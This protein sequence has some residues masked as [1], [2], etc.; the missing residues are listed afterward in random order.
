MVVVGTP[1][2]RK[3]CY[4]QC[5]LSHK[6]LLIFLSSVLLYYLLNDDIAE[7]KVV[8]RRHW[9]E[10]ITI[11]SDW[12]RLQ[13][14]G[15][16]TNSKQIQAWR[17][18]LEQQKDVASSPLLLHS[19]MTRTTQKH[20]TV[21]NLRKC[22][23]VMIDLGSN[24]GDA[25]HKFIDSFLPPIGIN[26]KTGEGIHY[27]FNTTTGGIGPENYDDSPFEW[28]LPQYIREKIT[29]YN[30]NN[31]SSIN[32][33]NIHPE[34]Y[35]FYGVEGNPYFTPILRELEINV[36]NMIPR[37]VKH[38]HFLTEHVGTAI[39]GP[40]TL[41]LD[42]VN[43]K[44]NFWGSSIIQSHADVQKSSNSNGQMQTEENNKKEAH[45]IGI[46]LT[47]LLEQT[48]LAGGHVIIKID[49]EGAEYQ[50][51]EEAV[52]SSIFCRLVKGMGVTIDI[53]GEFHGDAT[54]GS[55]EPRKRWEN[56][57]RGEEAIKNC[58]A[59]Y[60]VVNSLIPIW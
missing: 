13:D 14:D 25:L 59:S 39:D 29:L 20:L 57:I 58:G 44:R 23:Y 4:P 21:S 28:L 24:I 15:S 3:T 49:I 12:E 46:T 50:L 41:F 6:V 32:N 48:V 45:V 56:I 8:F 40:T 60:R 53:L 42:T 19:T 38:L 10:T 36:L 33:N 52:R 5:S 27:F 54:L 37:P 9:D 16:S 35:C 34:D 31:Y 55:E 2:R 51:L 18:D 22:Q 1:Q 26:R 7:D 11:T 30:N 43:V 47:K 17:R